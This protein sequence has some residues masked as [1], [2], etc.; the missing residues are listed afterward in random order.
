MICDFLN[1]GMHRSLIVL[2]TQLF[3]IGDIFLERDSTDSATHRVAKDEIMSIY[4]AYKPNGP[5]ISQSNRYNRSS[6]AGLDSSL[7]ISAGYAACKDTL[8]ETG[9]T[10]E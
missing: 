3:I 4:S 1:L 10:N 9:L 7:F 6:I 2:G 5:K 8:V